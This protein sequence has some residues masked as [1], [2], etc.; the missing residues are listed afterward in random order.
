MPPLSRRKGSGGPPTTVVA[1][2]QLLS[3]VIADPVCDR[4]LA[5]ACATTQAT[6][7]AVM[8]TLIA[9]DR[10]FHRGS[11]C[12]SCRRSVPTIYYGV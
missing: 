12:G 1:V 4:C 8:E 3:E 7:H 6:I 9:S 2:R 5:A 11:S 10:A